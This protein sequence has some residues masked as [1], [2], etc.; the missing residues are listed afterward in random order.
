MATSNRPSGTLKRLVDAGKRESRVVGSV[1]RWLFALPKDNSRPTNVIH[2][3]AMI[4]NDWCHRAEYFTIQ[5]AEPAPSKYK[6]SMKQLLTFEEGHRIHARWQGWFSKM[7]RLK[8]KWKCDNCN[9]ISSGVSLTEC[10]LCNSK[11]MVYREVPVS[12]PAHSISGH[13]DGWLVGFGDDLLLEIKSVGEG[14]IR[15]ED[16]GLW[17]DNDKDFAKAWAALKAPFQTHIMQAQVYLKLLEIMHE[18]TGVPTPQEAIFIYESKATQ[19]VKEFVVPKSDF[20][21]TELFEAA[22]MITQC[23]K[24]QTPP[25]CNINASGSCQKCEV[26]NV[27]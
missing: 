15:W 13:A 25:P 11:R 23:V 14:T 4:K 1:E 27:D 6:A 24:D 3:S 12:S 17:I 16:P 21:I 19:E 9:I 7:G 18:G 22:A 10:P 5:G 20:G 26:H 2:P 8:G